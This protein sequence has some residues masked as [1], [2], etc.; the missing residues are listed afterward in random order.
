MTRTS[1]CGTVSAAL[2]SFSAG[3]EHVRALAQPDRRARPRVLEPADRVD[4]RPGGVH[5]DA[6]AHVDGL[7]VELDLRTGDLPVDEPERDDLGAVEDRRAGLGR[8]EDV[9][10]AEARVVRPGVGVQRARAEPVEAERRHQLARAIRPDEPV[11]ARPRERRVEDD[12]AL[13]ERG[14]ERAVPVER[15]EERQAVDEVRRDVRGERAALVVRLAH[16]PDVAEPQ[17]AQAAVDELRRRAR[18]SRAEVPG[19]DERDREA[20]RARR[21]RP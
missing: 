17:V 21:G 13:D 8:R 15:Q 4:P 11:Q 18:G 7:A 3:D 6:G 12:P 20:L 5:D 19:V 16:E 9:L 10:E 1:S 2:Q 14:P